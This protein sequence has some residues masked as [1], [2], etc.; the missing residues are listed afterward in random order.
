MEVYFS[1]DIESDGPIPARNSMLSLGCVALA[2]NGEVLGQFSENL[3]QLEEAK[4]DPETMDWWKK[5]PEAWK[6]CRENIK[7][8]KQV[9]Q[10]F[11]D[12]ISSI[13][14]HGEKITPV[15][16][17][18]PAGFDFLFVY[19]YLIAFIGRSPFSFSALDIKSY[20]KALLKIDYRQCTKKRFPKKWFANTNAHTHIA[21]EDAYEQ[22]VMFLNMM[23]DN[24]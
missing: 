7:P 20:A 3:E 15:C 5:Q 10:E 24:T 6:K 9:M 22:G 11:C 12:W 8:A 23:K 4:E 19:W 2:P 16:I 18:Y 14:Y 17:A 1:I 21:V 13:R